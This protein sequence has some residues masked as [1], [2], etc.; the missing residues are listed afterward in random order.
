[1]KYRKHYVRIQATGQIVR[2]KD[3]MRSNHNLFNH[4]NGVPTTFE[5]ADVLCKQ[6]GYRVSENSNTE[7]VLYI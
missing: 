1:M 6:L 3:F 4:A 2:V 5:I 7:V